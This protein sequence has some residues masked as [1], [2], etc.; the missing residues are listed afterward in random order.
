M[1]SYSTSNRTFGGESTAK[2]G[3][4]FFWPPFRQ[5]SISATETR[6][7]ACPYIVQENGKV[8]YAAEGSIRIIRLPVV[9]LVANQ[10]R[11]QAD[12][13]FAAVSLI[14]NVSH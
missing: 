6:D 2:A 5:F 1:K 9:P 7:S 10:Q 12:R 14:F 8:S 11:R 4:P 3:R 13:I